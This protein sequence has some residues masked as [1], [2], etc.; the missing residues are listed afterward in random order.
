MTNQ[1]SA[2]LLGSWAARRVGLWGIVSFAS[3]SP[4]IG[5]LAVFK[6]SDAGTKYDS[7]LIMN[8]TFLSWNP[9]GNNPKLARATK[10]VNSIGIVL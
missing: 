8:R 2:R 9:K 5:F 1:E 10:R 3:I 6:G 7:Q 4:S